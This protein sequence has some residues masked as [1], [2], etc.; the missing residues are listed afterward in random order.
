MTTTFSIIA[1]VLALAW[2]PIVRKFFRAWKSRKNPVSLA[3][4][5]LIL[6][7]AYGHALYV[8]V[9]SFEAD[10][11]WV[12]TIGLAFSAIACVNFYVSFYWSEHKFTDQRHPPTPPQQ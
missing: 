6:V 2:L 8:L 9:A 1:A 10:R 7:F 5:W 3:I 12:Q 11:I 4:S